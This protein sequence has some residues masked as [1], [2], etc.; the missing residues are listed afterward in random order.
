MLGVLGR[1]QA[2][3]PGIE[4]HGFVVMG[5]HMHLLMTVRDA[6]ELAAYMGFVNG[7]I[8]RRIGRLH[9]WPERFWGRR[10]RA[11][12]V[13]DGPAQVARLQYI[14]ENGAKE[15][16]VAKPSE[17]PGANSIAALVTGEPL[18]GTWRPEK[19]PTSV[20]GPGDLGP[21]GGRR[22]EDGALTYAVQ[23]RPLPCWQDLDEKAR[24]QE[25]ADLAV[26][27]EEHASELRRA[28]GASEAAD[29]VLGVE[30]ILSRPPHERPAQLKRSPAPLVHASTEEGR[31]TFKEAYAAFVAEYRE[32]T[33]RLRRGDR[34]V[35]FP[36]AAFPP[37]LPFVSHPAQKAA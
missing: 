26:K 5:N 12:V 7:N 4:L 30:K 28:E 31:R 13:A 36:V 16:G 19:A 14:F 34:D 29:E 11:I 8:A 2:Q 3:H 32:A 37:A 20:K 6:A 25:Y 35:Q 1:A 10:F 18:M 15:G 33:A 22:K 17:W 9:D 27:A 21:R 23:L 24:R